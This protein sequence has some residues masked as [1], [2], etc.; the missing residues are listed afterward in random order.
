MADSWLSKIRLHYWEMKSD[1]RRYSIL[2]KAKNRQP[3]FAGKYIIREISRR[4]GFPTATIESIEGGTTSG[5]AQMEPLLRDLDI[6]DQDFYKL[7]LTP[8]LPQVPIAA[9]QTALQSAQTPTKALPIQNGLKQ[10]PPA[11]TMDIVN[12][13]TESLF[14]R[15]AEGKVY[16]FPNTAE[17]AKKG[18]FVGP[19]D[20]IAGA[21]PRPR[22]TAVRVD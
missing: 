9:P 14:I 13:S 12:C 2:R 6:S 21:T 15:I 17:Y 11:G 20:E 8:T 7:G 22:T 5:V 19:A 18:T 1:G 10:P 16:I 3:E 4:T